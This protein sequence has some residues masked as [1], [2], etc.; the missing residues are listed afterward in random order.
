MDASTAPAKRA[1]TFGDSDEEH[2]A[3]EALEE[4]IEEAETGGEL[5]ITKAKS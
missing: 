5:A 3:S 4:I 1:L 2:K